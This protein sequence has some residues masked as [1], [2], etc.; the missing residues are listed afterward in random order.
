MVVA[1]LLWRVSARL[2]QIGGYSRRD[3]DDF[4]NCYLEGTSFRSS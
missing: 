2:S 1:A 3:L 4:V